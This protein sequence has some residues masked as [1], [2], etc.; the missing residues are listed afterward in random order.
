M[1]RISTVSDDWIV[2]GFH[3]HVERVELAMRPDHCGGIVFRKVFRS[4]TDAEAIKAAKIAESLLDD[5][6]WR[7][8]FRDALDRGREYLLGIDGELQD[9]ARARTC[10][11]NYLLIAIDRLETG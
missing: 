11:L 8:R 7:R 6:A 10:E 2:K 1:C 5:P 4:T 9:L 3:I